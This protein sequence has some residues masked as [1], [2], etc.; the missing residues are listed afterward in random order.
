M[1]PASASRSLQRL[2]LHEPLLRNGY[3][4]VLNV[5][6]A[7]GLGM[8]FWLVAAHYYSAA[9]V[10]RGSALVSALALLGNFAQLGMVN[11]LI[12][13]LPA[14]G[15]HTG[16]LLARTYLLSSVLAVVLGLAFTVLAP[17]LSPEL[18]FLHDDLFSAVAFAVA[19]LVWAIFALQD[20][21]I[22][23]LRRA[24][25]IPAENGVFGVLK[26]A[27]LLPFA[28]LMADV[29]VFAAW[30]L[31]AAV[32]IL[33]VNI[34][35]FR[36]WVP[37]HQFAIPPDGQPVHRLRSVLRFVSVDYAGQVCFM[38]ATSALPLLVVA[39]LGTESNGHFYIAWT[40]VVSLD[41]LA[42][43]LAQS[44]TVEASLQPARLPALLR[45][46]LPTMAI[47]IGT[48]VTVLFTGASLLLSIYGQG[49][50]EEASTPLRMLAVA[51]LARAVIVVYLAVARVQ[52]RPGRILFIQAT[53]AVGVLG[54]SAVLAEPWGL[55][56]VAGAW[57]LTQFAVALVLTPGLVR[58]VRGRTV[59]PEPVSPAPVPTLRAPGP[60][61][62]GG[63]G[64]A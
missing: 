27:L 2:G 43:N 59:L 5:G 21:A 51:V 54:L 28:A 30:V 10:G 64:S 15:R 22:I 58:L 13:F 36:R 1:S 45:R 55:R 18:G 34:V 8:A 16:R 48:A 42:I 40:I 24:V 37:A 17:R 49:Y 35:L 41:L 25:W 50:V 31:A 39:L 23:G 19:V 56:G 11:G 9:D 46:L 4:L 61:D 57:L 29:G 62:L 60:G 7:T 12:R 6:V 14:A 47:M 38:F 52:R 63:A 53:T 3:A 33:P 26:L 20:A 44:L 32:L